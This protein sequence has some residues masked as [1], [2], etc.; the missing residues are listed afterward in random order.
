MTRDDPLLLPICQSCGEYKGVG[1]CKNPRCQEY[2]LG[3]TTQEEDNADEC[4][5]QECNI[6]GREKYAVCTQCDRVFCEP[7]SLGFNSTRFVNFNQH[8]GTCI[9]C[10]KIVCENCWILGPNGEIT[11]LIHLEKERKSRT[12]HSHKP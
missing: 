4:T 10:Q 7:H 3:G 12:F 2:I 8:L 6:C 5:N 1:S 11:C 9:E